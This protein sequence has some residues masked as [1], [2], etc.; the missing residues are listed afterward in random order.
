MENASASGDGI[1]PEQ[2][3]NK[4]GQNVSRPKNEYF[5][6]QFDTDR[7]RRFPGTLGLA[8]SLTEC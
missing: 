7:S 8:L 2:W 6:E 5:C 4:V 1:L 3:V